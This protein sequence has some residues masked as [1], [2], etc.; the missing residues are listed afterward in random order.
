M[1]PRRGSTIQAG[2][3]YLELILSV[4]TLE[5]VAFCLSSFVSEHIRGKGKQVKFFLSLLEDHSMKMQL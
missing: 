4:A 2:W 1:I 3:V 5:R